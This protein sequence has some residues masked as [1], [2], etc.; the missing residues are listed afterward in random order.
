MSASRPDL[1]ANPVF[2]L[3][4]LVRPEHPLLIMDVGA[5][6]DGTPPYQPLIDAGLAHLIGFEPDPKEY[7]KLR[8]R[9]G[10]PHRIFPYF[11][12]DGQPATF[13]QTNVFATG[14][15]YRPNKP[16]LE[17]FQNLYELVTPV[18]EHRVDTHTLDG[19]PALDRIDYLK[20]DVQ[21]AELSVFRGAERLLKT[22]LLIHTEVEFFELYER[23][24]LFADIDAYLRSQGFVL[25]RILSL[26]SRALK[27]T[28]LHNNINIGS[29]HLWG[30]V[31]YMRKWFVPAAFTADELIRLALLTH[32]IY[33]MYDFS[34]HF[35]RL[36]DQRAGTD[37]AQCYTAP[38]KSLQT[39][40]TGAVQPPASGLNPGNS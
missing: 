15:L 32:D 12:G 35:L 4:S 30:D 19:I 25:V 38:W 39:K 34:H 5:S 23:Q 31:L 40:P 14:S 1:A 17:K 27:P 33:Q 18:G 29:Q 16:L 9:Y 2:S 36:L 37:Y 3:S 10:E 11:I 26:A 7:D 6:L 21:G 8:T 20:I 28:V 13:H 22:A 24:P